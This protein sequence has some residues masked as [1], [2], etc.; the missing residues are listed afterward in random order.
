[1]SIDDCRREVEHWQREYVSACAREDEQRKRAEMAE[2]ANA[3]LLNDHDD[4]ALLIEELRKRYDVLAN[5]L[6]PA[7]LVMAELVEA[8]ETGVTV[9]GALA[10]LSHAVLDKL[11]SLEQEPVQ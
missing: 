5:A 9:P 8:Y 7:M 4:A 10:D 3:A 11:H 6:Q 1:M 2:A